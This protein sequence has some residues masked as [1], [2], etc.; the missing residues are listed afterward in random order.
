MN[1]GKF[2][3]QRFLFF[4]FFAVKVA[5]LPRRFFVVWQLARKLSPDFEGGF[6]H[7]H[8]SKFA[9]QSHSR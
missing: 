2:V 7:G 4:F 3:G 5:N 9:L 6:V 8:R 1:R